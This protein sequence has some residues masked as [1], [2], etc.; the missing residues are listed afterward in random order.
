MTEPRHILAIEC[1]TTACSVAVTNGG[2]VVGAWRREA[3]QG[4]AAFLMPGVLEAMGAAGQDF[5][6]LDLIAAGVGPGSFTGLRLGLAAARG[7][8]L[9]RG[10]P[11]A[12]AT[13]LEALAQ[14]VAEEAA[15][16]A[17]AALVDSRRGDVFFQLFA[18]DGVPEGAP[19]LV[20][21]NDVASRLPA[22]PLVLA[23]DGVP[24]VQA[25]GL[26]GLANP[27]WRPGPADAAAVARVAARRHAGALP[28]LLPRPLYLRG[29]EATLGGSA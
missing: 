16:C 13:S 9:A 21:P 5:D 2:R 26:R 27:V 14:G 8:A 12:V 29:P 10:I 1:A 4:H 19:A 11:L 28:P 22:E 6:G 15:G 3:R 23:G 7:I 25:A 17:A 20:A 24:L 18:S